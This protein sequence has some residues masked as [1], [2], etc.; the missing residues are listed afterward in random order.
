MPFIRSI[1]VCM[2]VHVLANVY[3][4]AFLEARGLVLSIFGNGGVRAAALAGPRLRRST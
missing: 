2:C 4:Q 1:S 3:L